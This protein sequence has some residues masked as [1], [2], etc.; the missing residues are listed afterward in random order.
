MKRLLL[1][2][3][4]VV[5]L[6]C[7]V[8]ADA[9]VHILE[10]GLNGRCATYRPCSVLLSVS[11]SYPTFQDFELQVSLRFAPGTERP[12]APQTYIHHLTL[13]PREAREI[14]VPIEPSR[15]GSIVD[16][17]VR[18]PDGNVVGH[19]ALDA[20]ERMW[21]RGQY[22]VGVLCREESVCKD[23]QEQ[24]Q[25]SGSSRD[26]DWKN[27]NL[28]LAMP[29]RQRSQWWSYAAASIIVMAIPAS[30]LSP[31]ERSALEWFARGGGNLVLL[32]D[33]FADS[34]FLAG[35]RQVAGEHNGIAIGSG[36]L[37]RIPQRSGTALGSL[38]SGAQQELLVQGS[39][40]SWSGYELNSLRGQYATTFGFPSW[41]TLLLWLAAYIL[42]VGVVTLR[43]FVDS[44][45]ESGD[46]LPLRLSRCCSSLPFTGWPRAGDRDR[47]PS[48]TW[49]CII[50]IRTAT[51]RSQHTECE[52][53]FRRSRR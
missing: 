5:A 45:G 53:P 11:N 20:K 35:Y 18:L 2:C 41:W 30:S 42:L 15:G 34:T 8:R 40:A 21:T 44:V 29:L 47:S 4:L 37:Y 9:N 12:N 19:D 32:E 25:L 36:H 52:C 7:T 17:T 14:D 13:G 26:R 27:R 39:R 3:H 33:V 24:I 31:D 22:L 6:A 43:S 28:E 10:V 38:F 48:T 1:I 50:S 16:V 46:G 23:I 51:K 49:P